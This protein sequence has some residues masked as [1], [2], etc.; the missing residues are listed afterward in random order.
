MARSAYLAATYIFHQTTSQ[1][2]SLGL[3]PGPEVIT[4]TYDPTR[5]IRQIYIPDEGLFERNM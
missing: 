3:A 2:L 4:L 5:Q 1:N